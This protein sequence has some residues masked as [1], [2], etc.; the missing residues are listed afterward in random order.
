MVNLNSAY[1]TL[2]RQAIVDPSKLTED[3]L[4][5]L[6]VRY[7]Y[8]QPLIFAYERRKKLVGEN[9]PN[10][11]LALLYSPNSNWLWDFINK[12]EVLVEE[13]VPE[14]EDYVPFDELEIEEVLEDSD[15][16]TCEIVEESTD[17]ETVEED[18]S[19]IEESEADQDLEKLMNIG[20]VS[21][22]Y[23]IFD[24]IEKQDLASEELEEEVVI[25]K[26]ET[27][28][29]KINQDNISLYNDDLM[30]Y[31]FRWWLHKT[32]LEHADTYQPFAVSLATNK[33]TK[34]NYLS[35]FEQTILDQ[36]IKEN[37]IHLQDPESKLSDEVKQ[38]PIEAVAPKKSD[39]IIE[40]FIKEEPIIQPP[41]PDNLHN[42]NMARQSAED[43]YVLVTETLANIYVDQGLY[44]KA[45]EV[46][47]K[48]ILK[49]PEKKSYFATRIQEL[50]KNL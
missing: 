30:P 13:V 23:F 29:R 37:I 25:E 10:K 49:Y 3:D 17:N 50:E 7:P 21:A 47:K 43:N 45:I 12:P 31:S 48:L 4:L 39:P 9:S 35:G 2:Y 42:E 22:D 27:I 19:I 6:I 26:E 24:K 14:N 5:S 36:Q 40:K 16:H 34:S 20:S 44:L 28:E 46:F 1:Y 11:E 33:E 38:R 18:S 32:R 15:L 8:S 41:A